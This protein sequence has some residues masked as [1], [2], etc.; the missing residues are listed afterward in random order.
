MADVVLHTIS[1][2]P[3]QFCAG[4]REVQEMSWRT[5]RFHVICQSCGNTVLGETVEAAVEAWDAANPAREISPDDAHEVAMMMLGSILTPQVRAALNQAAALYAQQ[6]DADQTLDAFL[7]W[8][9]DAATPEG[10]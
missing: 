5:P 7:D 6:G 10:A 2:H 9:D 8:C 3:C 1:T 4:T